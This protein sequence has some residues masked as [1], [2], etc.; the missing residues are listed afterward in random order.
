MKAKPVKGLGAYTHRSSRCKVCTTVQIKPNINRG[1]GGQIDICGHNW[2]EFQC[3]EQLPEIW[4][5]RSL[6]QTVP[7]WWALASLRLGTAGPA[8]WEWV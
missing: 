6:G 2:M 1:R 5:T 8:A 7:M 4:G 3:V